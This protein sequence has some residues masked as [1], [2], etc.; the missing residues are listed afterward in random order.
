M[1]QLPSLDASPPLADKQRARSPES[2]SSSSSSLLP[3]REGTRPAAARGLRPRRP[4]IT[5]F[6]M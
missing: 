1:E 3:P 2:S 6:R 4:R 5:R